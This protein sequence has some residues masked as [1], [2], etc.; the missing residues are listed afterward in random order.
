MSS[1]GKDFF[2]LNDTFTIKKHEIKWNVKI[3]FGN[4]V[5]F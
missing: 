3:I 4:F 2:F 5:V 1:I